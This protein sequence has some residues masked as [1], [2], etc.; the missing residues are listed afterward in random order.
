MAES[1]RVVVG[2]S[3]SLSSLAALHRAVA[4]ARQRDAVLVPVLAWHAVGGETAYRTAPCPQLLTVWEEAA[5][6]RLDTAFEQAFGGFPAGVRVLPLLV[7]DENPGRALVRTAD[8]PDDLLV[9]STG[10][11]G[12]L[13][14]I[15]HGSVSRYCLAHARCTVAAVPPSELLEALER[16][17]DSGEPMTLPGAWTARTAA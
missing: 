15:L 13:R 1:A 10:R 8:R 12:R 2:V 3:G 7:R 9:V 5:R 16:A 14:R 6:R 17:A 11:Q 4:E